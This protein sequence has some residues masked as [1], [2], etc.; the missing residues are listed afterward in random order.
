VEK[1]EKFVDRLIENQ[2]SKMVTVRD[3]AFKKVIDSN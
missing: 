3:L 2:V 1:Y